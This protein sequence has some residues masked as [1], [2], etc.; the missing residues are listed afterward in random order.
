M[1]AMLF[2]ASIQLESGKPG[3]AM[4]TLDETKAPAPDEETAMQIESIKVHLAKMAAENG[5][6]R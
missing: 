6:T 4:N 2:K 5:M 3:A 1:Q